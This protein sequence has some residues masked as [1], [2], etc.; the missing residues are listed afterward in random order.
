[1]VNDRDNRQLRVSGWVERA[2]GRDQRISIPHRGVRM[3]EEAIEAY[4]ATGASIQMAHKLVD[5]VFSRPA[6]DLAQE[7][8]GIGVTVLALAE[9]AGLSADECEVCEI[10]RV[11]S[12]PIAEFTERNQAKNDAGFRA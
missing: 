12:K 10:R 9:A 11:T 8:G 6:G 7:L 3:L 1:M 5:Y 4:Q 2:F